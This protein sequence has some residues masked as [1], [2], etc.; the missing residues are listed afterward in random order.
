MGLFSSKKTYVSSSLV[1]LAGE[2][3]DRPNYLKS[4]VAGNVIANNKFSI[5]ETLQSGLIKGP[6]MRMRTFFQWAEN[7]YGGIGVPT[8]SLGGRMNLD[9]SLVEDQIPHDPGE[10]IRLQLVEVAAADYA[11]WAE[12]WMFDHY[13]ELVG[14]DWVADFNDTTGEIEITFEDTTTAS[15]TPSNFSQNSAYIY[16]VYTVISGAGEGEEIIGDTTPIDL[17]TEEFPDTTGWNLLSNDVAVDPDNTENE[18]E[19]WVYEKTEYL[20][21]HPTIDATYSLKSTLT[22]IEIRDTL[23]EVVSRSYQLTTLEL[24]DQVWSSAKLFIYRIGSG[25]AVLDQAIVEETNSGE[26]LPFIP[27]RLDNKFLSESFHA[28]SYALAKKAYKRM[29]GENLDNII[30]KIADNENLDEIDYAYVMYGVPLNVLDNNAREYLFRFFD[31]LRLS[32]TSSN[33]EYAIWASAMTAHQDQDVDWMEWKLAQSSPLDPLYGTPPPGLSTVPTKP[34]NYVRIKSNGSLNTNVD[35][36][37]SWLAIELLEGEGLK[38]PGAKKGE[39]WLDTGTTSL[40]PNNNIYSNGQLFG[41]SSADNEVVNIHW[42]VDEDNWKTL[43]IIG[44]VHENLIYKGKAVKI[45][46]KEALDDAEESGFLVPIHMETMREMNFV[47]STQMSTSCTFLVFNSYKVVKKKWYQTGIFKLFVFVAIIVATIVFPPF[48]AEA[49]STFASIGT[50]IG[51]TGLAAVIVG[52]IIYNLAMMI[53]VRIIGIVAVEVLGEKWGALFAAVASFAVA[54]VGAGMLNG[55][56]FG[57]SLSSMWGNMMSASNLL[58]LTSAVGNGISGFVQA[59]T[60][61]TLQDIEQMNADYNKES[62]RISDLFAENLGYGN[63]YIDPMSLTDVSFGNVMETESQFLTRTLMTGSDIAE[64]SMDMLT[65][66]TRYT[67]STDLPL[68]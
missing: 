25:N 42:Q 20:G 57:T 2:E 15:F 38:K 21:Q 50:A 43:R 35:M 3:L 10:T 66:F 40:N 5:T 52:A 26:F 29:S 1:N 19:T 14:S 56:S 61:N 4:L 36:K 44:A 33:V 9:Y 48:G 11:Y 27:I 16:A 54:Q 6:G 41:T 7:H 22:L 23:S 47:H 45:T 46:G 28:D 37:I 49:M 18:L 64:L 60:M 39:F 24:F 31:K 30:E 63:G 8:G 65:N 13:P 12:Q 58:Q 67:L 34:G 62:K 17:D 55:A 32:Q 51:L 68:G 53:I 59:S